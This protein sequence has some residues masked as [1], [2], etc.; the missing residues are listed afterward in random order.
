MA[1]HSPP[2][3]H[4]AEKHLEHQTDIDL[5]AQPET[6]EPIHDAE[7]AP[8]PT[9][10][11][12]FVN[13]TVQEPQAV[14]LSRSRTK[15]SGSSQD[16]EPD[17]FAHLPDN[18]ASILRKQLEI[19]PAKVGY[20][21]L[22]RYAD[23]RDIAIIAF[24]SFCAIAGGALMPLMPVVFGALSGTFQ[25]S[26]QG[27][28][29]PHE[30]QSQ[31]SRYTL[32]FV[33]LAIGMFVTLFIA[34]VGY[35]YS[36]ERIAGRIRRNFLAAVLRQNIGF[37]DK[38]GAG[39]V[40][41]RITSDTNL[42]QQ[43]ISEKV[44]IALQSLATFLAAFVIAFARFWKLALILCSA[45]VAIVV[46]LAIVGSKL[47][48]WSKATLEQYGKG[49]T[50]VEEVISSIRNAVS[51]NA[52]D[53]LARRYDVFLVAAEKTGFKEKGGFGLIIGLMYFFV[54][55]NYGLSFWMGSR[56]LVDGQMS[57]SALITIQMDI[58]IAA[59]SLGNIAPSGQAMA[60]A[61]GAAE[62]IFA[63]IDRISPLDSESDS[64]EKLD[65][66][67]GV[68][69]LR[70]VRHIYPSRP[71]V[72]VM[73]DVSLKVPAGKTTALVGASGSGKSTIVGLVERF[74]SPVGGQ[75][76]LDGHDVRDLNL[77]WLRR[78]ISL[79]SQEPTLFAA[80]IYDN[81]AHGLIGTEY[82]TSSDEKKRQMIEE[83][84]RTANAHDFVT[85]LP[86][87]YMTNVGDRGFLLSG[88]QKQRIAIAR[89]VVSDPKILLLDEATSALDTKSEG[90]VQAALEKAAQGRTTIVIAH[91]LSTIKNADNIVVMSR[92]AI[93]EQGTHSQLL[94]TKGT[95]HTLIETQ[96]FAAEQEAE[97]D[98]VEEVESKRPENMSR[99]L[100][101]RSTNR[102]EDLKLK[103]TL[104]SRS[105][106]SKVL[107]EQRIDEIKSKYSLWTLIKLISGFNRSEWY[108]MLVGFAGSVI[109]GGADPV[110]AL[111]FSKS[112][113]ALSLPPSRY[114]ELR[115]QANFWSLM[116]LMVAVV[117]LFAYSAR[118]VSFAYCSER[119][120]HRARDTSFRHM[121]RQDM[122]YFD[123]ER[124]SAGALATFLATETTNLAGISGVTL[125]TI[126]TTLTTLVT[127]MVIGLAIGWKLS[128]VC[129][130][131]IPILLG[132]GYLRFW[133]LQRFESMSKEAYEQ[134]AAYA[135]E[136]ASAIRTVASLTRESDVCN[137]YA[138]KIQT[139]RR[140]GIHSILRSSALY[141]G[142]QAMATLCT[143]LGF[144]YGGTL[145]G[146]GEYSIFQFFL[147]FNAIVF[148]AQSAGT[149]F[150][151][152]PDMGKAKHAAASMKALF[153]RR[154]AID[155][156]S[157]EGTAVETLEGH[158][159]FRDVHFR[160][161]TRPETAVLRGLDLQIKPG[162]YIALVGASGC[163]KSTTISLLERFYNP[164]SGEILI[165]GQE[166]SS[167]N[168]IE[169]RSRIAL[170]SQE[171]TLYQGTIRENILL[172]APDE[173]KI[174]EA[175]IEQACR[176]AN[177]Y[178]FVTSLPDGFATMVG[179]KG[180]MLSGGQKQRIAIARALLNDPRILLLDEATS[181]LDSES[182]KVV[183]QALD[184]AAKGRTTVAVAHRL[185]TIQRADVIY[186]IDQ[187][188]VAERGTHAE[189]MRKKGRYCELVNLQNLG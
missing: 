83:A 165:D 53:K 116:Y 142:C 44:P 173:S 119:L 107:E 108:W 48:A 20:F 69:E 179:S 184:A 88:G 86:E 120:I 97:T 59:F 79:V 174:S 22:Y 189:L 82:E 171:P 11:V 10:P 121:L 81:I 153:D 169:Y 28:I 167:I 17:P 115:S 51:F 15:G 163:G 9:G 134:S 76:L 102:S 172:G 114:A 187:G 35:M 89:A 123:Q 14:S 125:G 64:G 25:S 31:L 72:V 130:S 168:L 54:F 155:T 3:P 109:T 177:I 136:A 182:E 126:L 52:Q 30:F 152:A 21:T 151:F 75:F 93:V 144:W 65:H 85:G 63:T 62:K 141:A 127:A 161:P 6:T 162:Q 26:Y 154:P 148:G 98:D 56:F 41:T 180:S 103:Q 58:I 5:A 146:K 176:D 16:E 90:V 158:I 118:G 166:L 61:I 34:N 4:Q 42:I 7:K 19:P 99:Q 113:S 186:V 149:V 96:R 73:E 47:K 131:T 140:A 46:T 80:T 43:G 8:I 185:S 71:E 67:E 29:T 39:E 145:I 105:V 160:Y 45:I 1:P 32:Y 36:G 84:A 150:A 77:Q 37:F 101:R 68:I 143:A 57:L 181:A 18:E 40:T 38:L 170:V 12:P 24:S 78:Q 13:A 2:K 91:R 87:G 157:K 124:H 128:L 94:E 112:I 50:L 122:A 66:V 27:H 183:Q 147:C 92:G 135:C 110:A 74:Y 104:T 188:R 70:N 139:Q 133:L 132:C 49:G 60:T 23:G 111:F 106:S 164:L 117:M 175:Q 33:Y 138:E 159:E 55:L 129:I 178:D 95:Y 156:W 100:T 137:H